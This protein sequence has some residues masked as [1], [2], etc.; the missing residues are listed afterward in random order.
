MPVVVDPADWP[1]W[2]GEVD[3]DPTALL[4]PPSDGTLRAW[5]VSRAVNS[6][7]NNGPELLEPAT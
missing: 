4:D 6:T 7:R 2:L 5:P 3:S 1:A